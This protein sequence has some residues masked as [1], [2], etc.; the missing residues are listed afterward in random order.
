MSYADLVIQ[1]G[2]VLTMDERKRIVDAVA[3]KDGKIFTVGSKPEVTRLI[4][5]MTEVIDLEGRA[6]TPGLVDTHDHFLEHGIASAFI[7]DVRYPKARS[8]EEIVSIV[9]ERVSEVEPG[10]WVFA[11]VWDEALLEEHRYPTRWD[12]DPVSPE[13]P[14]WL[15]RVF[16]M[17]VANSLALD[18]AGI[19]RDTPDPPH[20]RIDKDEK[21]EPTGLVRGSARELIDQAIPEWSL[22]DREKAIRYACRDFHAQG[23]TAVIEPGL[24]SD[25][26]EAF[27]S[28]HRK[29]ELTIRTFIDVGVLYTCEQVRW[30]VDNYSVGGDDMLRIMGLKFLV[31]GGI[32][33]RTALLYE[34]YEDVPGHTGAQVIPTGELREM[35]LMAHEAGFQVAVHAIGGKAIDLVMDAFEYAQTSFMRPD[36]RHQVIHCYFPS[37]AAVDKMLTLGVTLNTQTPFLYFLGD[38][39]LEAL[40]EER[41]SRCMPIRTLLDRG[42]PVATSH[43]A[44]VTPPLSSVGLYSAVARRT[45]KG[46]VLGTDEAVSPYEAL[47]LYAT[48]AA[49]HCFM[50]DKLGSI[51]VGKYADLAVWNFNPLDVEP[52]RLLGWECLMTFVGGR[53]VFTRE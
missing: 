35:T 1:N 42:V 50:E 37:E 48:Q 13:N 2:P 10:I 14:V 49:R 39:F 12:L 19:T 31:D 25:Q 7:V 38:S 8:I 11:N 53:R 32:G 52:E 36:P 6:L 47:S 29:G 34:P 45:I 20:G 43:D 51:E 46:R 17:G 5:P 21:G 18:L 44:T 26:I 23:F 27:R 28:M 3:V 22:E 15:K 9:A 4:G 30:A 24:M 33:P 40:G 16:Q 41:C